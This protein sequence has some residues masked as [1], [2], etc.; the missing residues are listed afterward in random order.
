MRGRERNPEK[1]GNR[2]MRAEKE[3]RE[4]NREGEPGR[5]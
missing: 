3:G 1:L 5:L 4:K 2:A